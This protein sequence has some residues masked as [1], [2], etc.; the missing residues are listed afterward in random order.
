M[1]FYKAAILLFTVA[2]SGGSF[3]FG[4][5][6][7][8]GNSHEHAFITTAALACDSTFE[9]E[10]IPQPCFETDTMTNLG[11]GHPWILN[12]G[13]P[14]IILNYKGAQSGG[15]SAVEAPDNLVIHWSGGPNWWHCD[16]SDY[17]DEPNYPQ[18]R[19]KATN[20]LL[21]CRLWAQRML[22]DGFGTNSVWCS[23]LNALGFT[24]FRCEGVS[25]V[26]REILDQSGNVSVTQPN[27]RSDYTGCDFN[28]ARGNIKCLVLQQFGY[29]L[30]AVQDFYS[31]SNYADLSDPFAQISVTN[32]PGLGLTDLPLLW[33]LA[34]PLATPALLPDSRLSVGCYPDKCSESG[35]TSHAVLNKDRAL[36]DSFN[37]SV[38]HI[39][40]SNNP[41]GGIVVDGLSN[42]QR[43]VTMAVRQTRKAW[44]DL[45]QL[46][47]K[48]EG[49]DRGA[50]IICAIAS[51]S[52]NNCG[53]T[54]AQ[55]E[56]MMPQG[57]QD[58]GPKKKVF[59]WIYRDTAILQN[60]SNVESRAQINKDTQSHDN[61]GITSSDIESCGKRIVD[62]HHITFD[63]EKRLDL[64]DIKVAGAT[65]N[66]IVNL[67]RKT[68]LSHTERG[69]N[70]GIVA[71]LQCIQM[72]NE[73]IDDSIKILCKNEDET[74]Q[75]TFL[76]DC[77]NDKGQCLH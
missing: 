22:G 47:I 14:F 66:S 25:S 33:N 18:S 49:P 54:K 75:V 44:L 31:H 65:C 7:N 32:P 38:S 8:I 57:V 73:S 67:L 26:A 3:S 36:I 35:R 55:L 30:H 5:S 24:T 9:I 70:R 28:G 58:Y 45:Q 76:P 12:N 48:K 11:N 56:K 4:S 63:K 39:D 10:S 16:N 41:R 51:D 52:P 74:I 61:V 53:L 2:Y 68:H 13:I 20:K 19:I 77:G 71:P 29:A 17:F 27:T 50:K 60:Q 6:A 72:N 64:H 69:I 42:S 40:T 43:A 37:A 46:I 23:Q 62:H 34:S 21:D 15:F 59:P 1:K